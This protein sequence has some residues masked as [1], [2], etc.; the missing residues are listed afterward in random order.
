MVTAPLLAEQL[1]GMLSP[2]GLERRR[3]NAL[4]AAAAGLCL[5]TRCALRVLA[6]ER[7]TLA[8]S[9]VAAVDV[10]LRERLDKEHGFHHFDWGGYLVFRGVPSYVDGRLEPFLVRGIFD[11]YLDIE[12]HGDLEALER[13]HVRWLLTKPGS[14]LS[15]AAARRS[16]WERI[17]SDP[18]SELLA[19]TRGVGFP[20]HSC[21]STRA[22]EAPHTARTEVAGDLARRASGPRGLSGSGG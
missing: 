16:D 19:A 2:V 17:F 14:R 11:R 20:S 5:G 6:A 10:L 15:A 4:F 9:P 8:S 18:M 1:S 13:M 3:L 12:S 21:G 7:G 22:G